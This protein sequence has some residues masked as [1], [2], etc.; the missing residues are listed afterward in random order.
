M[1]SP[2]LSGACWPLNALLLTVA[3]LTVVQLGPEVRAQSTSVTIDGGTLRMIGGER[4][5]R[6]T[7]YFNHWGTQ[8]IAGN[9]N[10]GNLSTDI[11]AAEG[12]NSATGRDTWEFDAYI[13]KNIR[14]DPNRPGYFDL[15][16]LR[17]FLRNGAYRDFLN[18]NVR[19]ESIREHADHVFVQSGRA[20]GSWPSWLR[21]GTNLP[22]SHSGAAYAEFLNVYYEEVVY[23]TGPQIGNSRSEAYLPLSP[24]NFYVEIMNEPSWELGPGGLDWGDAIA[25]HRT[26]TEQIKTHNPEAKIGGASVGNA[27]FATWNPYR[28]DYAK[29]LMDDMTTWRTE[30]GQPAEFDFWTF[31]PYDSRRI[32]SS[33]VVE[34]NIPE[35]S[36]H[37]EGILD[38]FESY[39]HQL[40]GDPKQFAVTEYGTI[41]WSEYNNGDF[42]PYDRRLQQ[43]D[44]LTDVKKKMLV[45]MD[46]PDRILNATPFIA[47]QWW[48]GS[49][50]TEASAASNV[51]WDRNANGTW[52][53]TIAAKFYRM[54]NDVQGEYIQVES[55]SDEIQV[56]GFRDGNRLHLVLNNLSES[57]QS[58]NLSALL[59]G[60]SVSGASLDRVFWNGSVG[61]Y[62]AD[63]DVLSSWQNLVLSEEEAAKLTLTFSGS[64]KYA[65][66]KDRN[67]YYGDITRTPINQPSGTSQVVNIDADTEDA[68][69]AT[70]RVAISGRQNIWNE[71]FTVVLN[72][73]S[74]L[75]PAR[76]TNGF[77]EHDQALFSR[78]LEVPLALL[79][80]GNNQVYVDFASS[81]GELVTATMV[82]TRSLGDFNGNGAF[83]SGDV[84]MLLDQFGPASIDSKY[85]LVGDDGLVDM[86]DV[87]FWLR[88]LRGSSAGLPGDYN[89][90]GTVNLADYTV[91]R[92]ALGGTSTGWL[93]SN[94]DSFESVDA[95]DYKLWRLALGRST[96]SSGNLTLQVPEPCGSALFAIALTWLLGRS[97][98]AWRRGGCL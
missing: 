30:D 22:I 48:T 34:H 58:V 46:R 65:L 44:E 56:V 27:S 10:L 15:N 75:V 64:E 28:W 3:S 43:W 91:W 60:A 68:L 12:L 63:L 97:S 21:Q 11:W 26:V 77:D 14:E 18:N 2:P 85:D 49:A 52:T 37:L 82:L 16:A 71:P 51:F 76:G 5:L 96:A 55:A 42:S 38:L 94:G 70:I 95:T 4:E 81:G 7:K 20:Q 89:G 73:Q 80:D 93:D 59:G 66:A 62:R 6:R 83:D 87:E 1:T 47:P 86:A 9:T 31:H 72:G 23:G 53:E 61:E 36:G 79:N 33:G 8:V 74:I 78:E 90:D 32:N 19:Y 24:E 54:L 39:S 57:S 84:D 98:T 17:T 25:L 50:P 40:F 35:S 69:S 41:Q 45:F 92:D 67:T 88:E 13:A 29:T